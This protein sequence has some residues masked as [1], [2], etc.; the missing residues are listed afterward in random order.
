MFYLIEIISH[1]SLIHIVITKP[2]EIN[3]FITIMEN[4]N[5]ITAW[6]PPNWLPTDFGWPS[7]ESGA[8][9]KARIT[10]TQEDWK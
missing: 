4:S 1:G 9:K 10:F 2:E 7:I 3:R 8:Y 5:H 6:R